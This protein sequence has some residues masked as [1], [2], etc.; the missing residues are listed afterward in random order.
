MSTVGGG[1]AFYKSKIAYRKR[2]V[3]AINHSTSGGI[4]PE[5][6]VHREGLEEALFKKIVR[7][8]RVFRTVLVV[9]PR[10]SGK[11]TLTHMT[12]KNTAKV[13]TVSL[14]THESFS[15]EKFAQAILDVLDVPPPE[16]QINTAKNS[17]EKALATCQKDDSRVPIIH[18]EADFRCDS[19]QLQDMLLLLKNW[20]QDKQLVRAV[21]TL[22]SSRAALGLTIAMEELRTD[23]FDLEDYT[24]EEGYQYMHSFMKSRVE[25]SKEEFRDYCTSLF[26][27][28][29]RRPLHLQSLCDRL[30]MESS[31]MSL[32]TLE[33]NTDTYLNDLTKKYIYVLKA[34]RNR[35]VDKEKFN[36]F[37][38]HLQKNPLTLSDTGKMLGIKPEYFIQLVSELKP[39]PFLIKLNEMVDLNTELERSIDKKALDE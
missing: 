13:I 33:K 21:V 35:I 15:A 5:F 38:E 1:W 30:S 6:T 10:G 12:L 31:P 2:L 37:F 32:G 23:L 14:N 9:G 26:C 39:Q 16:T 4:L 29:G 17:V 22:S 24:D 8:N 11:S 36:N 27:R 19:N 20:G 28:L 25:C 34:F 3:S 18:V 7:P